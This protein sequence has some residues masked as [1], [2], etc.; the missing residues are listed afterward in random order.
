MF[1]QHETVRCK[2][3]GKRYNECF[4][5]TRK[6]ERVL[7][8]HFHAIGFGYLIPTHN[9]RKRYPDWIIRN[10]GSRK[11]VYQTA[12]YILTNCS[13]WRKRNGCLKKAYQS[14]GHLHPK[15]LR[16]I[17]KKIKFS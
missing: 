9:F 11:D 6:L 12:F 7:D 16:V 13:L 4:C 14:Y 15:K 2:S 8:I 3:C 10:H 1:F 17:R 5:K